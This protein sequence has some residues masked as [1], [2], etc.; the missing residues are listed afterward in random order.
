MPQ[1][2]EER[3]K[4]ILNGQ[5][6][7]VE[8]NEVDCRYEGDYRCKK[9]EEKIYRS[10]RHITKENGNGNESSRTGSARKGCQWR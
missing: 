1:V 2:E 4:K 3:E 8:Q 9:K 7:H 6:R 5:E 10:M